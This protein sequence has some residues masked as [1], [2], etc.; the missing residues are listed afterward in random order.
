MLSA[1]NTIK[2]WELAFYFLFGS[3]LYVYICASFRVQSSVFGFMTGNKFYY[4][5]FSVLFCSKCSW[6][7]VQ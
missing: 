3:G 6:K 2:K 1:H 4:S 7:N 5:I